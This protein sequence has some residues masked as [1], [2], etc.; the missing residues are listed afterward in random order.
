MTHEPHDGSDQ[1][2]RGIT[3]GNDVWIRPR[4]P[5]AAEAVYEA[6]VTY[7]I[8]LARQCRSEVDAAGLPTNECHRMHA[9]IAAAA[10][11]ST[12]PM[13]AYE[14]QLSNIANRVN[15]LIDATGALNRIINTPLPLTYSRHTSRALSLWCGT[16]PF[17][18]APVMAPAPALLTVMS[19][20]WLLFGIEEI[21]ESHRPHA[22]ISHDIFAAIRARLHAHMCMLHV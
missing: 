17:V 5:K 11:A 13:G 19:V 15:S 4:H 6:L 3:L 12:G 2:R 9:A 7:P 14:L 20:C 1:V 10:G 8:A 16:L 21:G 22:E 18:L